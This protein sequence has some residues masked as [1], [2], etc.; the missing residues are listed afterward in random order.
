MSGAVVQAHALR[1]YSTWTVFILDGSEPTVEKRNAPIEL[2]YESFGPKGYQRESFAGRKPQPVDA[3]HI[4]QLK[5]FVET[6]MQEL[7]VPGVS[8]ALIDGGRVVYKGGFRVRELGKPDSATKTP[9]SWRRR[10]QKE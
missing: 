6:S 2:I 9:C 8:M 10:T 4:A 5:A 3:T 7:G 1:A